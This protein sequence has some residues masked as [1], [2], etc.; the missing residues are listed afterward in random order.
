MINIFDSINRC[1]LSKFGK[2]WI[3]SFS[4]LPNL[5]SHDILLPTWVPIFYLTIT[6]CNNLYTVL[7]ISC[8]YEFR[9]SLFKLFNFTLIR[10]IN[11]LSISHYF[12][13]SDDFFKLPI[14]HHYQIILKSRYAGLLWQYLLMI[15]ALSTNSPTYL[16]FISILSRP[17]S[18]FV[19][20]PSVLQKNAVLMTKANH[21][22]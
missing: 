12:P 8:G 4:I 21:S 6:D 15:T 11:P 13:N 22:F 1:L 9:P 10:P 2:C 17:T 16:I 5:A 19:A 7:F 3:K 14:L 18:V 20:F